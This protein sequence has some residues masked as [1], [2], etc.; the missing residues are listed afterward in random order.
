MNRLFLIAISRAG[1]MMLSKYLMIS[2]DVVR[3]VISIVYLLFT[4]YARLVNW[5]DNKNSN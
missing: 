4:N 3:Q 1:I 5:I 2:W